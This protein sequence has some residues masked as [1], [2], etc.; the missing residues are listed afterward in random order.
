MGGR[1]LS[2]KAHVLFVYEGDYQTALTV[3][4]SGPSPF[5]NEHFSLL[6]S[7]FFLP[8]SAAAIVLL[9]YLTL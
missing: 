5:L 3:S 4:L 9:Q 2:P 1:E 6:N 8:R 7:L